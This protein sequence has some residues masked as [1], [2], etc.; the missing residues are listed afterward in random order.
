MQL[1][2]ADAA[3]L[4]DPSRAECSE[5]PV[6]VAISAPDLRLEPRP[7][8]DL[9]AVKE[10]T[11]FQLWRAFVLCLFAVFPPL[12]TMSLFT[13][14]LAAANSNFNYLRQYVTP[15]FFSIFLS[16]FVEVVCREFLSGTF[17]LANPRLIFIFRSIFFNFIF[18]LTATSAVASASAVRLL[19]RGYVVQWDSPWHELPGL[20]IGTLACIAF[21]IVVAVLDTSN[22][23]D[24]TRN[25][26]LQFIPLVSW[27]ASNIWCVIVNFCARHVTT[28]LS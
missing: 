19:Q 7:V 17:T 24:H 15:F 28:V 26:T 3:P 1:G 18:M 8:L 23:Y 21:I 22:W 5:L 6:P 4:L 2:P 9:P 25:L 20:V 10:R 13:E 27:Y 16:S 12:F 14:Q 11:T